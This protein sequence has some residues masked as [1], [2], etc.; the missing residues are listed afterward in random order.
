MQYS[1]IRFKVLAGSK[2]ERVVVAL[3]K[4]LQWRSRA[5]VPELDCHVVRARRYE[6]A[7]QRDCTPS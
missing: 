7:V 2:D 4:C 6:L 3:R 5:G 1:P